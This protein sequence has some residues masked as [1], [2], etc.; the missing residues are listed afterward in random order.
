VVTL[1]APILAALDTDLA[2]AKRAALTELSYMP[3]AKLAFQAPRFWEEQGIYGGISWTSR[4]STQVWYPSSGFHQPR[5]ILVGAYIWDEAPGRRFSAL[6]PAR[7]EAAVRSD[8]AALHP[9]VDRLLE[10]PVSVAW[11]EMPFLRG[12]WGEYTA[13]QRR[14]IY[15]RS[16]G[17]SRPTFS[18][19]ALFLAA[20]MD[21]RLGAQRPCRRS[22]HRR[23]ALRRD[24]ARIAAASPT[25]GL[26]SGFRPC[27]SATA[28]VMLAWASATSA[29]PSVKAASAA[30]A[31]M[32]W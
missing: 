9:G 2:A 21:G 29:A 18:P 11:S 32:A 4:D 3:A 13:E 26:A 22:G 7:R 14:T 17:P 27:A 16:T 23:V 8:L 24:Q 12:A 20:G 5:G 6:D 25:G 30:S 19:G 15:R 1:P 31:M 10:A 28:P